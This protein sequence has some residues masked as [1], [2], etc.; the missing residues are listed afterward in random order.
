MLDAGALVVP[1]SDWSVVPSVNPWI[2]IEELV[3]REEPGGSAR[4]FGKAEAITVKE[5]LD[6]F[7][8]NSARHLG[9]EGRLGRIAQGMVADLIVVD[10]DPF[11][12]PP[13]RI[14]ETR[15]LQ[16]IINGD[17]VYQRAP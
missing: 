17:I 10:Q 1:G 8:I 9:E 5:A 14:H 4:S 3:T 15:V 13:T 11:E 2:A 7:T 16:T 12:V 6:L